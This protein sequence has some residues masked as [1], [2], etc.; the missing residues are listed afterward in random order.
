MGTDRESRAG[1]KMAPER[2]KTILLVVVGLIWMGI[3]WANLAGAVVLAC[4]AVLGWLLV[5]R[6]RR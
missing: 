5:K 4:L 2:E 6:L 1:R 3:A